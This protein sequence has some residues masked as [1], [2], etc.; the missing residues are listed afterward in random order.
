MT[1][2]KITR[3]DFIK[4]VISGA[5]MIC[6]LPEYP[7]ST[8]AGFLGPSAISDLRLAS[9]SN[10]LC[11]RLRDGEA[12]R[13]PPASNHYE[14]IIVGGGPSGLVAAY[15]LRN[16]NFLLLEKEPRIGGNAIS[17]KWNGIWYSTG[18]AWSSSPVVETLFQEIGLK[19]HRIN[20]LDAAIINGTLVAEFWGE[21]IH[22]ASYSKSVRKSFI[23]FKKDMLAIDLEANKEKLDQKTFAQLLKPYAPELKLWF[24]NYG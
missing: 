8:T 4:T 20:S 17:E 16:K 21:G 19:I 10:S 9:E 15:T 24:D 5:T 11:H 3:R 2:E 22:K 18:V 23:Q 7:I 14:I 1:M 13:F 12:F 6:A